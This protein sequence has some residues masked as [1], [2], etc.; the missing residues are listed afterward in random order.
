MNKNEI[1]LG[2]AYKLIKDVPDKSIDLIVTDPPYLIEG[3]HTGTGMLKEHNMSYTKELMEQEETLLKGIDKSILDEFVRVMK[4]INC[5]IWC[6][7]EQILPIGNYFA[8]KGCSFNILVWCKTNVMPLA[9]NTFLPNLEY[10]LVLREAGTKLNNDIKWKSKWYCSQTNV[11]DKK[12]FNHP[13][14]KPLELVK[15]HLMHSTVEGSVV[16]DPFIGSGTTAVACKELGRQYIGFEI[17]ENY[18]KIAKARVEGV[19]KIVRNGD[20]MVFEQ[21]GLF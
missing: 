7:K 17:D 13:T 12:A 6:S 2:D 10:C 14:I 8:G 18:W 4:K 20:D 11:N 15:R 19:K 3:W 16:L 1:I 21:L 5:Y 9:H